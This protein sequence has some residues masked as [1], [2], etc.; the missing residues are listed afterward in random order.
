M[1]RQPVYTEGPEAFTRFQEA[2]RTALS[3]PHAVIQRRIEEQRRESAHNPN[4]RG[5]KRK[6]KG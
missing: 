3:V 6:A 4:R 2:M 1:K 5:P